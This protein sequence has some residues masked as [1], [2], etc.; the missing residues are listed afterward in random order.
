MEELGRSARELIMKKDPDP[1]ELRT[2]ASVAFPDPP[3]AIS[4]SR[5]SSSITI[6]SG[7]G[8]VKKFTLIVVL[9]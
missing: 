4:F 1:D 9:V 3:A 6:A 2:L 5:G 8:I 7:T